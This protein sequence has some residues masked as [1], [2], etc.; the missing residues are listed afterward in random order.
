MAPQHT[1]HTQDEQ[2]QQFGKAAADDQDRVDQLEDQGVP[3]DALPDS[4][5]RH[6]RAGAKA[7]PEE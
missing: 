1:Q 5:S 2:D 7:E 4:P 3:P 6:P